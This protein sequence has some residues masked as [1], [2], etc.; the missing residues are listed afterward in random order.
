MTEKPDYENQP[1]HGD[2]ENQTRHADADSGAMK[3]SQE[4]EGSKQRIR[5][6]GSL[7]ASRYLEEEPEVPAE[8]GAEAEVT[9]G[10]VEA[11]PHWK[12]FYLAVSKAV[13]A[14]RQDP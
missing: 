14:M 8:A 10:P 13:A 1:V 9:V 6:P 2:H 12:S 4:A 7:Q 5:T 11:S 3:G